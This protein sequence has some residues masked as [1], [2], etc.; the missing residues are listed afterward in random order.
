MGIISSTPNGQIFVCPC[1]YKL[2]L[3]FGNMFLH[4]T[5]DELG[6]FKEYINSIDFAF[7]LKKNKDARSRRKLMLY[8]GDKNIHLALNPNEFIE[9]KEL[10][11]LKKPTGIIDSS[12][13]IDYKT[14]LN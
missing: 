9:L 7:Y 1:H 8:I 10:L 13:I 14:I 6:Y 12:N 2:F 5:Y 3:E 11:S 4:L